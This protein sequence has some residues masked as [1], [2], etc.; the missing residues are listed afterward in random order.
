MASIFSAARRPATA[1]ISVR[2]FADSPTPGRRP[3]IRPNTVGSPCRSRWKTVTYLWPRS[4]PLGARHRLLPAGALDVLPL[5]ALHVHQRAECRIIL[6]RKTA[7]EIEQ[8]GIDAP[9]LPNGRI[10]VRVH[11]AAEHD[12]GVAVGHDLRDLAFKVRLGLTDTERPH[13]RRR[14]RRQ[15][16]P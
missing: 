9:S 15:A 3:L 13:L 10:D 4:A 12:V 11:D 14:H 8:L 6:D 7:Y 16:G 2:P 1:A 5:R